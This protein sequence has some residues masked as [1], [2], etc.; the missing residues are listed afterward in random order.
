[1]F[2][3][4]PEEL[5]LILVIALIFVGP[6]RLPDMA[7]Q[8]GKGLREFKNITGSAKQELMNSVNVDLNGPAPADEFADGEVPLDH[9]VP[10]DISSLPVWDGTKDVPQVPGV[11]VPAVPAPSNGN[12]SKTAKATKPKKKKV[13]TEEASAESLPSAGA[14]AAEPS[15][16]DGA[17][18][19][20]HGAPPA[21]PPSAPVAADQAAGDGTDNAVPTTDPVEP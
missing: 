12:G 1:M 3:I 6:K 19:S 14:E 16:A 7:R 10:V 21:A 15:A 4:G 2:N 9:D 13:A 5:L 17:P 20:D 8:V 18:A 11:N